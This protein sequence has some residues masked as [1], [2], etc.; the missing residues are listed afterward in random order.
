MWKAIPACMSFVSR[1][2]SAHAAHFQLTSASAS[3]WPDMEAKLE[4]DRDLRARKSLKATIIRPGGLT[5]E[6]ARG[7]QL[8]T[9][10]LGSVR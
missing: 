8:G 3:T 6:L 9:P 1:K 7:C 10:Q 2:T 4:A 5:D